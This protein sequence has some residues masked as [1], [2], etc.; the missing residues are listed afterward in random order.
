L[1]DSYI[2]RE[3]IRVGF[4]KIG[5]KLNSSNILKELK[6]F[7]YTCRVAVPPRVTL[8][9]S[10][11]LEIP[12]IQEYQAYIENQIIGVLGN[13]YQ[14]SGFPVIESELKK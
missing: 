1:Y 8:L 7:L 13:L 9:V 14:E 11:I 2:E 12:Q 6:D 5:Y 4:H 3:F 10:V